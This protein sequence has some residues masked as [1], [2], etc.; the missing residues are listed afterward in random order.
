MLTAELTDSSEAMRTRLQQ[1]EEQ[2]QTQAEQ[3]ARQQSLLASVLHDIRSP[4]NVIL[5]A[6]QIISDPKVRP[7][8]RERNARLLDTA[9]HTINTLC[10]DVLDFSKLSAGQMEL[11]RITFHLRDCIVG[12]TDGVRLIAEK[13]GLEIR[14]LVAP[15]APTYLVGDPGRLRQVL[16]NLLTNAVKFTQQGS[17]EV[18]IK[19]MSV[20]GSEVWMHFEVADTGMG[21]H[22]EKLANLFDPFRQAHGGLSTELGGTGLGL[23]IARQLVGC[24]GGQLTVSSHPGKGTTF[25]FSACFR[26]KEEIQDASQAP[27]LQAQRILILDE[28][29][30]TR[31]E[32]EHACLSL[33]LHPVVAEQGIVGIRWLVE[34]AEKNCPFPLAIINLEAGGGDALFMIEQIHPEKRSQT[35]FLAFTRQGQRGDAALCQEAGVQ[36]YLSGVIEKQQLGQILLSMLA[37]EDR[38]EL[39]TRHSVRIPQ[40]EA[41]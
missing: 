18:R 8:R 13:K 23:A 15:D 29:P 21:I 9:A 2:L 4:L 22:Q 38:N 26:A 34:A 27:G 30:E 5:V 31:D 35:R 7:E 1:L 36:A 16:M 20:S 12:L 25:S 24:M 39:I 6:A 37:Q 33:G 32:L 11:S 3:M 41:N 17:V 40:T 14:T 10:Q 28:N 19:P